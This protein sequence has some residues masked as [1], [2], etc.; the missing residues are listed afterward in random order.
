MGVGVL[1]V[2]SK[3]L[4]DAMNQTKL[5]IGQPSVASQPMIKPPIP[6]SMQ[7]KTIPVQQPVQNDHWSWK[8]TVVCDEGNKCKT[9]YTNVQDQPVSSDQRDIAAT[10]IQREVFGA[11]TRPI[12][13]TPGL[14]CAIQV[15]MLPS[16]DVMDAVVIQSSGDPIF[17]RSAESA[18]RKASPLPVPQD[19]ELFN[20]NFRVFS[21]IFKPE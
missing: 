21:F 16:G 6:A 5:V 4:G 2:G 7:P 11:W 20:S 15:K 19:K 13:A 12:N 9:T 10:A 18:V 14:K 8:K 17:D 1:A 3:M